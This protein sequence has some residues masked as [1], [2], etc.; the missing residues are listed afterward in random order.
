MIKVKATIG[1]IMTELSDVRERQVHHYA[2]VF[3]NIFR[4]IKE[5]FDPINISI[6]LSLNGRSG[7]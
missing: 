7:L 4:P 1:N 5:Q 2:F 3:I 6:E